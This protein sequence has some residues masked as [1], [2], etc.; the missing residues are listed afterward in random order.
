MPETAEEI[1]ARALEDAGAR[2]AEAA[3][4]LR[5][6]SVQRPVVISPVA[7]NDS[8]LEMPP[9]PYQLLAATALYFGV[10]VGELVS[11]SRERRL[12][13]PRQV[14]MH[15]M[16][17]FT[18]Q[19]L[20]EVGRLFE[21]DHTTVMHGREK[22]RR[23]LTDQQFADRLNAVIEAAG[24]ISPDGVI[25]DVQKKILLSENRPKLEREREAWLLVVA[26]TVSSL[27]GLSIKQLRGPATGPEAS[28]FR[29]LAIYAAY[30]ASTYQP[31]AI[32]YFF[33]RSAQYLKTALQQA[34]QVLS[35]DPDLKARF[36]AAC[37]DQGLDLFLRQPGE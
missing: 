32:T 14:A 25:P 2:L 6:M 1:L 36:E 19:S 3:R 7:L 29:S 30:H 27:S 12:I 21:R 13:L 37:T 28:R 10:E 5:Q 18:D 24:Q 9:T 20:T 35:R 33:G 15:L 34:E 23:L 22:V 11:K 16:Y 4:E 17:E 8:E 31:R 26:R